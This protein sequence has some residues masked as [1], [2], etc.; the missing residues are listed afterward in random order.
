MDRAIG[1]RDLERGTM[2]RREELLDKQA[3]TEV[4]YRYCRALDRND[5]RL[6]ILVEVSGDAAT[7][8]SYVTAAL[9]RYEQVITIPGRY[10]D[11]WSDATETGRSR[12]A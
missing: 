7:S 5:R 11:Y 8:R 9:W 6:G 4:L 2:D 1:A 10:I 12:S 3:I